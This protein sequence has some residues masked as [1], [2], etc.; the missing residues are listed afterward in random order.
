LLGYN[1]MADNGYIQSVHNALGYTNL[2]LNPNGGNVGIGTTSPNQALDV[3]GN[4]YFRGTSLYGKNGSD[5]WIGNGDSGQN[6]NLV[7]GYGGGATCLILRGSDGYGLFRYGHGDASSRILKA[8]ITPIA[9]ALDKV[10]QLNGVYFDWIAGGRH[11]IG[12]I[13][14]DVQKVVP[15]VVRRDAS[16]KTL[17]LSY[18]HLVAL[19]I[20]AIKEQQSQIDALKQQM[21]ALEAKLDK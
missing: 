6:L 21:S 8:N 18:D 2:L 17:S 4:I 11:D 5:V 10:S 3:N 14:E 7:S 13:A 9:N 16:E 19:T 20:E 15:E 12:M 1:T